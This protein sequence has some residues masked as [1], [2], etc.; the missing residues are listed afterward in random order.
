MNGLWYGNES[1]LNEKNINPEPIIFPVSERR[2][3]TTLVKVM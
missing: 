2:S 1:Q 3:F